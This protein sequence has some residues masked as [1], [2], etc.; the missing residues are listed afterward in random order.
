MKITNVHER[1]IPNAGAL[2]DTLAS[3]DDRVWPRADW[4]PLELDRP[5]SV[6]ARG[7]H[8]PVR[9]HVVAYEPGKSLV[10]EF[11]K[12]DLSDGFIGTHRFDVAGDI[13]THTLDMDA[14][15]PA[16]FRWYTFVAPLHDAL[17]EDALDRAEGIKRHRWSRWV[18]V[19]RWFAIRR[20]A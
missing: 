4:P 2:I 1:A 16:A 12:G 3:A 20:Y 8:G 5:L 15:I 10:F 19:L 14:T 17:V 13:V 11:E 6:G 9:Y 7:G 18:R